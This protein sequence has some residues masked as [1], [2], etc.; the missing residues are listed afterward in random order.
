MQQ[1]QT[2]YQLHVKNMTGIGETFKETHVLKIPL[3]KA[4]SWN[5][6]WKVRNNVQNWR[7]KIGLWKVRNN[8][9]KY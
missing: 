5:G 2:I 8:V 1:A 7:N 3:L 9:Q 6:F 4:R